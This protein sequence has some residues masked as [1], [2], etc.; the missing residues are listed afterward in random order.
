MGGFAGAVVAGL[1]W[2]A[3]VATT[4]IQVTFVALGVGW[5][6]AQAVLVCC[7]RRQRLP[8]QAV[9][10]A[11]TLASLAVSGTSCS[12]RCSSTTSRI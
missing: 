8:L 7:T 9:A 2:W 6:V 11:F 10:G 12:A 3:I 5:V 4:R 1:A